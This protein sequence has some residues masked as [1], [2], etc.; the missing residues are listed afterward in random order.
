[1]RFVLIRYPNLQPH[2][3]RQS[4]K[5]ESGRVRIGFRRVQAMCPTVTHRWFVGLTTLCPVR[6]TQKHSWKRA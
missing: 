2:S 5:P 4:R 3:Q 1:M 6:T